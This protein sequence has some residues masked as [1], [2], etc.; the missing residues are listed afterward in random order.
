MLSVTVG[1]VMSLR[2]QE[3]YRDQQ[4]L[5]TFIVD[6]TSG[7]VFVGGQ[8]TLIKLSD[9]LS[10][11][12]QVDTGPK[13]DSPLCPP[14]P[15]TCNRTKHHVNSVTKGLVM[16]YERN[17]LIMCSNVYQGS[18]Q[19]LD[20][21]N[22]EQVKVIVNKPMVGHDPSHSDF[23][24][25]GPGPDSNVLYVGTKYNNIN[26]NGELK[27]Y[28]DM[29]PHLSSRNLDNFDLTF[30]NGT[31]GTDVSL[32]DSY[33]MDFYV[34]FV[35]GFSHEH[36]VYF[37][38]LQ[39]KSLTDNTMETKIIRVCQKDKY[40]NSYIEIPLVCYKNKNNPYI[41][42]KAADFEE[43]S[44]KL[45]VVFEHSTGSSAVCGYKMADIRL[46]FDSTTQNCQQGSGQVGPPHLHTRQSCQK[47]V[48]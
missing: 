25:I 33:K 4:L 2:I 3:V 21:N 19:V 29:V 34:N 24:F 40:F 45:Y 7:D 42:A 46:M 6:Q 26:F 18:C 12:Q 9:D 48:R 36:F 35:Y 44:G 43:K 47:S 39:A 10:L 27:V 16:D 22:L 20:P 32:L 15:L 28:R 8:N 38:S 41:V 17:N 11:L 14:A 30:R 5:Q 23:L 13:M 1:H 37:I 31:R